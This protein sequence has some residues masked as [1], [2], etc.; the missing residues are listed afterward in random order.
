MGHKIKINVNLLIQRYRFPS[1]V[2]QSQFRIQYFD[3]F[4]GFIF[5]RALTIPA[6]QTEY[7]LTRLQFGRE[8]NLTIRPAVRFSQ[9]R[10]NTLFGPFSDEVSAVTQETGEHRVEDYIDALP[11]ISY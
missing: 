4:F 10:F 8:Y 2:T 9:C 7:T 11:V 6:S 5:P 3:E 1:G